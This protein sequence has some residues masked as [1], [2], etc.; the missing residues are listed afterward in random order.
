MVLNDKNLEVILELVMKSIT[1][2]IKDYKTLIYLSEDY[3]TSRFKSNTNSMFPYV[4]YQQDDMIV[5]SYVL[6]KGYVNCCGSDFRYKLT[7]T[8]NCPKD[9]DPSLIYMVSNS[10]IDYM[11]LVVCEEMYPKYGNL[12][13]FI[14]QIE[15]TLDSVVEIESCKESDTFL[16]PTEWDADK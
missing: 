4:E 13:K 11:G 3:D 6:F 14:E 15:A 8:I 1:S 5:A 16:P 10:Q 9:E 12:M 2:K 7:V